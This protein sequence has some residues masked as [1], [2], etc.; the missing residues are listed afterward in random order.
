MNRPALATALL[1]GVA[2]GTAAC[3]G[4]AT[5]GSAATASSS[6]AGTQSY[7]SMLDLY[8]AVLSSGTT[9][10][11]VTIQPATT[12]KAQATCDL[13]GGKTLV[14]QTWRDSASRDA[15]V[16]AEEASFAAKNTPYS[17]LAGVGSTGLWS[18]TAG[19]DSNVATAI[20]HKLGG[21]VTSSAS[22]H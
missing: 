13:G 10:S 12:A 1:L 6:P 17:A 18:V 20:S 21:T 14:L 9:C 16:K 8:S 3:G 11:D 15:G 19:G 5:S 7:S 4:Q 2:L 22:T